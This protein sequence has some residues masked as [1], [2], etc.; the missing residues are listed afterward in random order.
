VCPATC[1]RTPAS[2]TAHSHTFEVDTD[3]ICL[4]CHLSDPGHSA[5]GVSDNVALIIDEL[6]QWA[7]T[8]APA[9]LRSNGIVAWEYTTPGGLTWQTNSAGH[10]TGWELADQVSFNGPDAAGQALIPGQH[11]KGPVQFIS[12]GQ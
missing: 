4:N 9:V 3:N 12:R 6:N 7:A 5:I 1:N 11:Q 10:V 2:A 8:R